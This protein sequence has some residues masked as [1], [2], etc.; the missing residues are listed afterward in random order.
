[1]PKPVA[2]EEMIRALREF[3]RRPPDATVVLELTPTFSSTMRAHAER[4]SRQLMDTKVCLSPR[5]ASVETYRFFE[6]M[7]YGCVVV[8]EPQPP[9]WFYEGS[10]AVVVERWRDL[11]EVLQELLDDPRALHTRHLES[12]AWWRDRCSEAALGRFMA[13][14]LGAVDSA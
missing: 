4:Y 9:T 6:A 13:S 10:P 1:M 11:P 7:R 2:R 3:E 8:T 5:G 14:R 12:L